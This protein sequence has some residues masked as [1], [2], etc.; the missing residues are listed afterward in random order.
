MFYAQVYLN[1]LKL[2][3]Q[4]FKSS[5]SAW[6]VQSKYDSIAANL[7]MFTCERMTGHM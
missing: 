5:P 1:V 3:L 6:C 2:T 4:H 7:W